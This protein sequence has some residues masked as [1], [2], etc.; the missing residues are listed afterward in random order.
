MCLCD[1]QLQSQP[2]HFIG[3]PLR[4]DGR[5]GGG[6]ALQKERS[7]KREGGPGTK[8]RGSFTWQL[9]ISAHCKLPGIYP[10]SHGL[11]HVRHAPTVQ[12]FPWTLP[13]HITQQTMPMKP[14]VSVI[15]VALL[16]VPWAPMCP[17]AKLDLVAS[18]NT[19]TLVK[20]ISVR[21]HG[22]HEY[23][24]TGHDTYEDQ[25][26][27]W[28]F[29]DLL[30]LVDPRDARHSLG[31]AAAVVDMDVCRRRPLGI[32]AGWDGVITTWEVV[33]PPAA[34]F[35]HLDAAG[36]AR[37]GHR[38]TATSVRFSRDC[39]VA[40]SGGMDGARVWAVDHDGGLA[41]V[42]S[43]APDTRVSGVVMLPGARAAACLAGPAGLQ[44]AAPDDTGTWSVVESHEESGIS[45]LALVPDPPVLIAGME[46]G[47][48]GVWRAQAAQVEWVW[49]I[50]GHAA[51]V[52]GLH[53]HAKGQW[54]VS[55]AQDRTVKA[56]N[57]GRDGR[58]ALR[59]ALVDEDVK[60]LGVTLQDVT[61]VAFPA[62]VLLLPVCM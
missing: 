21:Q 53:V 32:S 19:G 46:N 20:T 11:S 22:A 55:T 61:G 5:G 30:K 52:L 14:F 27:V 41:L 37:G 40:I 18:L 58:L 15:T 33:E 6:V 29:G 60:Q 38:A 23:V 48:L 50:P 57:V 4:S 25:L 28:S 62:Q 43:L 10:S 54:L 2:D 26:R 9:R 34:H 3:V 24:I 31:T 51:D 8:N 49:S 12:A 42:Q 1:L 16:L 59:W 36:S 13:C 17:A 39:A 35:R 56:W 7:F 45:A 44:V 47:T